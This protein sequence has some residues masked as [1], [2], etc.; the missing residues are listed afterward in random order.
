MIGATA[1]LLLG[2]NATGFVVVSIALWC[3]VAAGIFSAYGPFWS[4]PTQFFAGFSAAAG[5]ALINCLGNLGGFV[6]PYAIGIISKKT[7]S[8]QPGL[9]FVG[10]LL[11]GSAVLILALRKRIAPD[12]R[13][14]T[15]AQVSPA[16]VP[17]ADL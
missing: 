6:G 8:L 13:A 9:V 10:L 4:L 14:V 1:L 3:L 16:A 11:F 17:T 15:I 2:I 7:G 12:T 5:I